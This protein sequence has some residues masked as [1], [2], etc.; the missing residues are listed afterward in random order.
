LSWD[1]GDSYYDDQWFTASHTYKTSGPYIITVTSYQSDGLSTTKF[2][3]VTVSETGASSSSIIGQV[4]DPLNY[5]V[6]PN[7][8]IVSAWVKQDGNSLVFG[9]MT[10]GNIVTSLAQAEDS[11]T[12]IWLVDTDLKVST[13]QPHRYLGSEFNVRAVIGKKYGG[14][15]VDVTDSINGGGSGDVVISNNIIEI[16]INIAQ[17]GNTQKFRWSAAT[18]KV[19][20]GV[21]SAGNDETTATISTTSEAPTTFFD[22]FNGNGN[23]TW[24]TGVGEWYVRNGEYTAYGSSG[25]PYSAVLNKT[26]TNFTFEGDLKIPKGGAAQLG[27]RVQDFGKTGVAEIFNGIMLVIF[28]GGNSIYWH[29]IKNGIGPAQDTKPLGITLYD[30]NTIHVKLEV[31][32]NIYKAYI[33]GQLVNTLTDST[34]SSGIFAL[35]VNLNY[36]TPTTWDNVIL[37][38]E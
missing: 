5:N 37:I 17:I 1:W 3:T 32:G 19:V 30:T 18:S 6:D 25:T 14:G 20:N 9:I 38:V 24:G 28:P 34:Y 12:Y 22:N 36:P 29:V 21:F 31:T 27:I 2:V 8:D 15:F 26:F 33:N 35:G 10:R 4:N 16:T 23:I 13:G 7:L 11:I